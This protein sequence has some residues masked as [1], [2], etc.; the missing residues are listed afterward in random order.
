MQSTRH[1]KGYEEQ[2]CIT[3]SGDVFRIVNG[4]KRPCVQFQDKDG[5]MCVN[6][7]KD[8]SAKRKR[9]HRL[10]AEAFINNPNMELQVNHIDGNKRNNNIENL[11]LCTPLENLEHAYLTGL[12]ERKRV[13]RVNPI[14]GEIVVYV[15]TREAGRQNGVTNS[16]I[17]SAIN[18]KHK[19]RG[20]LWRY[21][22]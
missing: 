18:R 21:A 7:S 5:Y 4:K 15:S 16:S 1:I 20:F 6:L 22:E 19:C 9:V 14:D 13:Q 17:S 3:S 12:H 8:G 10:V 2:Y 11:E